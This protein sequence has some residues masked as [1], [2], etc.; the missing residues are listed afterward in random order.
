[1]SRILSCYRLKKPVETGEEDRR[2]ESLG[3]HLRNLWNQAC[4]KPVTLQVQTRQQQE[5]QILFLGIPEEWI[6]VEQGLFR[7][8][9]AAMEETGSDWFY[10]EPALQKKLCMEQE[11][12]WLFEDYGL[13][14]GLKDLAEYQTGFFRSKCGKGRQR[15]VFFLEGK[16][17]EDYRE[18]VLELAEGRNEVTLLFAEGA[19]R[20]E[21]AEV[22]EELEEDLEYEYGLIPQ[23]KL[24]MLRFLELERGQKEPLRVCDFT[25]ESSL[26]TGLL[27]GRIQSQVT[28]LDGMPTPE[29]EKYGAKRARAPFF[30]RSMAE[31]WRFCTNDETQV[32]DT[33][34][35]SSYNTIVKW[36]KYRRIL[37]RKGMRHGRKEKH[38]DL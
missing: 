14:G 2:N 18:L 20:E 11:G 30:Y 7:I 35:K 1:M 34:N 25:G 22:L 28:Y 13:L 5:D 29:K 27:D 6:G 24:S 38:I 19:Q 9:R 21:F 37:D 31:N 36:E 10:L 4:R 16:K 32:I 12:Q 26:L 15:L 33:P 8:L 3:E 23:T 17:L